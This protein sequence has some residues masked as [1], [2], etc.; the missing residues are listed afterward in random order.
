[1]RFSLTLTLDKQAFGNR[2]PLSYQYELSSFIYRAIAKADSEYATW[3]HENGFRLN[4]KPF[5]LFTFSN[6]IIPQYKIDKE[7]G[8]IVIESDKIKWLVSFLPETST[9]KFVFGV[10]AE[11]VFQIGDKRSVV[12]FRIEQI[13]ALPAPVFETEMRFRT[14]SPVCIP[15]RK[16]EARYATYLSPDQPEAAEIVLN[17]LL[18]KYQTFYGKPFE[19][20][21]DF[22]FEVTNQPKA[23]LIAIKTGTPEATN[24]KGYTFDFRMTAPVELMAVAYHAGIGMYGSQGFGFVEVKEYK[25]I[26]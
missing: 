7:Q 1:M 8:R 9:E 12:Q 21:I 5:K 19:E 13:E 4:G 17:N 16:D 10:F 11:Q 18:H 6:L 24:V 25:K 2:L 23:K 3:L 14:L 15:L 26:V 20:K 22:K